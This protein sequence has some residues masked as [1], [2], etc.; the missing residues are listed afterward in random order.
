MTGR[1]FLKILAAIACLLAGA[2]FATEYLVSRV[3]ESGYSDNLRHDLEDKAKLLVSTENFNDVKKLA[4]IAH[5]RITVVDRLGKVLADSSADPARM[6]NHSNRPEFAAALHGHSSSNIR[7]SKTMGEK[8]LYL[9]VPI[10]SGAL[11]LAVPISQI[12]SSVFEIR[13]KMLQST[14]AIFILA[15]IVAAFFARRL[16]EKFNTILSHAAELANG[17]FHARSKILGAGE[18]SML[19]GKLNETSAKLERTVQQ[20]QS[21]HT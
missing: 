3:A 15:L 14:A 4:A 21:E 20:M 13:W 11:R 8:Y 9:A 19:S 7:M 10:Q 12:D 17:N 16:S 2:L 1:I 5:A 18:F 6:E